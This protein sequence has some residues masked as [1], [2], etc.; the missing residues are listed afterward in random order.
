MA[1]TK[2]SSQNYALVVGPSPASG[3]HTGTPS[4]LKNLWAVTACDWSWSN[5]KQDVLHYGYAAARERVS[6]EPPEVTLTF[7][8]YITSAY[9][10][11]VLGLNVY[12]NG[13]TSAIKYLLDKTKDEKNYF[14]FVAPEGADAFGLN[15]ASSDIGVIGIGNGFLSSYSIDVAVG[16]FPKASVQVQGLNFKT[17]TGGV[18]QPIPAV[19]PT[20]GLEITGVNFTIPTITDYKNSS[21]LQNVLRPGDIT[22]SLQNGGGLFYEYTN[23][24][25]QSASMSFDLNRASITQLGSKFATSKE[26]TFPINVNFE[27]TMLAK[28]LKTGSLAD[29]LCN[30]GTYTVGVSFRTSSCTGSGAE[31]FGYTLR[32]VSL[33]GQSA[34]T[35]LGSEPGTITTTWVG[36]IGGTGDL[37]NGLFMSGASYV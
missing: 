6:L 34:S 21:G 11:S 8:Y 33:E 14:L 13:A 16:D 27:A 19:N 9:N 2:V 18:L 26:I 36:Q 30:T 25:V 7:D 31:T 29:F 23:A 17:Y 35:P 4:P 15:G 10:E 24:A 3:I 32:N 1:R 20:T 37:S 5:P 22:V 28:D 12:D